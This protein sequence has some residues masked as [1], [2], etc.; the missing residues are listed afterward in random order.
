MSFQR[1]LDGLWASNSASSTSSANS[2]STSKSK[3]DYE[4]EYIKRLQQLD[5]N[6]EKTKSKNQKVAVAV[7]N[8]FVDHVKTLLSGKGNKTHVRDVSELY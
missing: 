6:D 2:S 7:E 4:S 1:T 3:P 8:V 5:P